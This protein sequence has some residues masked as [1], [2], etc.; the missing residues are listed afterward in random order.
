MIRY[1]AIAQ[2]RRWSVLQTFALAGT[3]A[4][5]QSSVAHADHPN[6]Q[7][8]SQQIERHVDELLKR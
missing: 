2:V 6:P 4:Q 7:L 3:L 5:A 1:L 8:A